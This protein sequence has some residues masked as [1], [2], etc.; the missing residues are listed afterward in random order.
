[1]TPNG[2]HPPVSPFATGPAGRCP[3]CGRGRLFAGFLTVAKRCEACDLDFS[4][5][6]SGDGPAV[7]VILI[8][9]GIVVALAV[10]TEIRYQ[11]PIWVHVVV[12]PPIILGGALSMLRPLKGLLIA[13][14]YKYKASEGG[15]VSYD[16]EDR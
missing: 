15:T 12:W 9:G 8:L 5:A 14:Q 3:R 6:D 13:L 2:R 11:P 10:I 4:K 1:M 16:D 7:F